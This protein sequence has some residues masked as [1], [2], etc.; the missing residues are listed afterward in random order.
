LA[1]AVAL[2][3]PRATARACRSVDDGVPGS[4]ELLKALY[5]ATGKAWRLGVTG[6]PGA[7]KSTLVDRLIELLRAQGKRVGVVAV[8]PSSPFGGGAVLG[9]RVRMQRHFEDPEVFIRSLATRGALG[10]LSHTALDVARILEAWGASVVL[11]ET[12]GV[13]QDELDIMYR[14][15]STLVVVPPGLG[16]DIQA[17]KA[18]ILECAD[19]FAVNK[20]DRAGADAVVRELQAMLSLSEVTSLSLGALGGHGTANLHGTAAGSNAA[21][22]RWTPP[23]LK[24]VATTNQGVAEILAALEGHLAWLQ[25]S[26][27]GAR[28]RFERAR[29]ELVQRLRDVALSRALIELGEEIDALVSEIQAQR[30]DPYSAGEALLAR[31]RSQPG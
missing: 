28:R 7:G 16:D 15:D 17:A 24:C 22:E 4:A 9:D 30:L 8:D 1:A 2:G 26:P 14:A 23:V 12:V 13:G 3:D 20:A 21:S 19:V 31:L 10:G 29:L 18:G 6:N 27:E 11:I 5:P 25:S